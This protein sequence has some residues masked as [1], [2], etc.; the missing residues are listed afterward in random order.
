M[1]ILIITTHF[2]NNMGALLQCY[3][4]LKYIRANE[5]SDCEVLNYL[6]KDNN[7]SWKLCPKPRC[8]KDVLK[9]AYSLLPNKVI[10][11]L[12]KNHVMK[13]FIS[14]YLPLTDRVYR[15]KDMLSIP[16]VADAYICGSD[17]IW[18]FRL[19]DDLTYY[20]DF[21][22]L[23]PNT[24]R[25]SYAASI[26][27]FWDKQQVE[28]VESSLKKF[29]TITLRDRN[30]VK[31]VSQIAQQ[32]V[33]FVCDPVFLLSKEEWLSFAKEDK[34]IDEPYIL[35]YFISVPDIAVKAV[36]KLRKRT[37]YKVIHLNVNVRDRF[38]SDYNIKIADP[39]D[40]IGL[41][42]NATYVCTNSFHCSCYSII[43]KKDFMFLKGTKDERA[44]TLKEI[45]KIPDVIM[46]P[47]SIDKL[48][49]ENYH[50]DYSNG[51]E[52]GD[53]FVKQSKGILHSS[54]WNK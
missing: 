7:L 23:L 4:L 42:K 11:K 31:S 19:F 15:R 49:N 8:F 32:D 9:N 21:C 5:T 25:I 3:A 16:P 28:K 43:F 1:K 46:T 34:C 54:I 40:F 2:A 6:P 13:T 30:F 37:G 35:C 20:L 26:T 22:D 12:K 48:C 14:N 52:S 45:F 51:L 27:N 38:N 53:L 44:E 18:N 17:Q 33:S 39:R 36:E 29:D 47:D 41:I 50:V 24:R 10:S